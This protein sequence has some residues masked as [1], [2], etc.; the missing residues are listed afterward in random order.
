MTVCLLM[1]WNGPNLLKNTFL[2]SSI[3]L[4]MG[5]TVQCSKLKD[6]HWLSVENQLSFCISTLQLSEYSLEFKSKC[7]Q[8]ESFSRKCSK[9]RDLR[10]WLLAWPE[11]CYLRSDADWPS[12]QMAGC[13]SKLPDLVSWH[14]LISEQDNK[15]WGN[16]VIGRGKALNWEILLYPLPF[17]RKS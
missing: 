6:A 10:Q 11:T 7:D 16:I 4:E 1:N 8:I 14:N 2:N 5:P 15:Q 3:Q 17:K 13:Q 9:G 12:G